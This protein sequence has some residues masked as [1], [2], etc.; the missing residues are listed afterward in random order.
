[1]ITPAFRPCR[2]AL[3]LAALSACSAAATQAADTLVAHAHQLDRITVTADRPTSLPIEIPTTTEGTTREQIEQRINATDSSDALKYLPSLV[4]RKRNIGDYDHAVLASRASGTGNSARS[5]VYADGILLSN[6]LGNGAQFTPRWGLV[7]PEEIERVD[8]LYGPFSA[9]YPGNSAGAIVDY[10]T[11]M[12]EGFEAHAKLK[13]FFQNY[14]LDATDARYRG[15]QG[16]LSLGDRNGRF[17]WW[18]ALDRL[19]NEGQPLVIQRGLVPATPGTAG[20]P[21]TGGVPDRDNLGREVINFGSSTRTR[22][23]QDH[24]KLKLALDLTPTVRATYTGALW[25]N[26]ATRDADTY[27][28][29]ATGT[30]VYAGVVNIDGRDYTLAPSQFSHSRGRFEHQAHGLSVKSRSRGTWDW[31]AAASLYDYATDKV[32]SSTTALPAAAS[33][34]AGRLVDQGGTGWS[35][36]AAKGIWRPQG[37]QGT[38]LVEFGLQRDAF[39]LRSREATTSDWTADASPVPS[40]RFEGETVLSSF[41]VQDT[42]R[43]AP[44]WRAVLGGRFENWRAQDGRRQSGSTTAHYQ[45]RD[46]NSFSPKA[47]VAWSFDEDWTFKASIGRAVRN[48]TVS[49]LYQ[50]GVD[51]TTGLPTNNDPD[52]AAEKSVTTEL[53]A[54]RL[55]GDGLWRTTLFLERSRD[56]LYSQPDV[57]F[58]GASTVQNVGRIDTVGLEIALQTRNALLPGLDLQGSL[59]WADSEIKS[60]DALPA[61]VGKRQPRVPEWRASLLASYA[62]SDRLQGSFGA[63]YSGTQYGQLDNSDVNGFSYMGFS[64]YFVTDVRLQLRID[65]QWRASFGIDNLNNEKYW[66]F[67]PYPQRTFHAELRYDH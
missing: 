36:L 56:A 55:L 39:K 21:V 30:P 2:R 35:T 10:V 54:E 59:T 27:L 29:D 42:W 66:A 12:P 34:G 1:M 11:R 33:G 45:E 15:G 65:R 52:L 37:L 7:T 20:T 18:L 28:R 62:F 17:A 67:H 8:V 48:P 26:D 61:S 63:R 6:L 5:L 9:A 49:E 44:G 16:S 51:T 25:R 46:E 32:S 50:G 19:D 43:F 41:W 23:R 4:V 31:E 3:A 60:N 64:R 58:G 57:R 47:A 38:H 14:K 13:G 53:S 40:S 22:T 24:A